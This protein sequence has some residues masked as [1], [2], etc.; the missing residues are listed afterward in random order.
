MKL[1]VTAAIA[2]AVCV[3]VAIG[4]YAYSQYSGDEEIAEGEIRTF[5][6]YGQ[7]Q[8]TLSKIEDQDMPV[9]MMNNGPGIVED[10][11]MATNEVMGNAATGAAPKGTERSETYVQVEGV[12]EAD[13]VKT[14]GN[15]IYYTSRLGYDVTIAKVSDGK[16]ADAAVISE[17]ES[18]VS[19]ENLFLTK[20]RLI[21]TG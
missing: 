7:I 5:D 10:A 20:D 16:A 2:F 11:E 8:R 4:I 18:G 6:S 9:Y 21:L 19:A 14:D 1:R 17:E 15:Y 3:A 12:D 13:I